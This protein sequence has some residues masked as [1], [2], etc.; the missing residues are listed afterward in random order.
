MPNAATRSFLTTMIPYWRMSRCIMKS[1]ATEREKIRNISLNLMTRFQLRR[2]ISD[3]LEHSLLS[4]E[5]CTSYHT[6]Q[7][8]PMIYSKV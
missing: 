7:L 8:R 6:S 4:S 1:F 2:V 5:Y 3:Q